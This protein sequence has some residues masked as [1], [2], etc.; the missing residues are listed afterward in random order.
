M[1]KLILILCISVSFMISASQWTEFSCILKPSSLGGI[2]V[3]ATHDIAQGTRVFT[4]DFSPRKTKIKELP[5]EFLKYCMLINDEE[6]WCPERFDR[7]E[8]GWYL[9]HSD[10]PNIKK[11]SDDNIFALKDIQEGDE[12]LIDYNDLNEPQHLKESYYNYLSINCADPWF[13]LLEQGLKPV[14]GRKGQQKYRDL[15]PGDR[16]LFRCVGQEREFFATVERVDYFATLL[17]YLQGVGLE[18][19]LPGA[20]NLEEGL[21]IY[22]TWSTPDE[23][24]RLG[25]VGIWIKVDDITPLKA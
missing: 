1:K 22:A 7:M 9:N 21:Q 4:G 23:I 18:K 2:G 8:I 24:E 16:L 20:A 15:K 3:F 12:I 13:S 19:A 10:H 17:D 5:P 14:E 25:F 6:C 11:V